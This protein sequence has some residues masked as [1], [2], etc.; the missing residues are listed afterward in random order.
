[1]A[2]KGKFKVG[3]EYRSNPLSKTSTSIVIEL[4][5]K[6]GATKVYDNIHS[7]KAFLNRVFEDM[8]IISATVIDK[9]DDSTTE[10]SNY[11]L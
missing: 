6:N 10:I 8:N 7:A 2:G 1:M 11:N 3:A 5:E 9:S 4:H